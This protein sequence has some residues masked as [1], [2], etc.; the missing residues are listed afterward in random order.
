MQKRFIAISQRLFTQEY[1]EVREALAL[2][3][4]EFFTKYLPDFLML[5]LSYAQNFERYKPFIA[6]VILS[7][8]NDLSVCSDSELNRRRDDFEANIIESCIKDSIP[9]L[10]ICRGA[11]MIA[12]YF[13][14][15][16]NRCSNHTKPHMVRYI[17][18]SKNHN[19]K[20]GKESILESRRD[21]L[22]LKKAQ[23]KKT[24]ESAEKK[25]QNHKDL[26]ST[27]MDSNATICHF[28][29]LNEESFKESS[30]DILGSHSQCDKILESKKQAECRTIS[31][32]SL[33]NNLDS[34]SYTSNSAQSSNY[35]LNLETKANFAKTDSMKSKNFYVRV[36][37]YHNY[38]IQ[39]L[40]ENLS[41]LAIYD[42]D[43]DDRKDCEEDNA[44][45]EKKNYEKSYYK[46]KDYENKDLKDFSV[47]AFRHDFH[48]IFGIMWHI[49]RLEG[50]NE[51]CIFSLWKNAI[52]ANL[53]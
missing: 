30:K 43:N 45:S 48:N 14:S 33:N 34:H 47:E 46:R 11:Q 2:E 9:L 23:N 52:E 49:E 44:S 12:H 18:D 29:I 10:G 3:W 36:N 51:C 27:Q 39:K 22:P 15:T 31:N 20:H 1:G 38:A 37:S 21:F 8:G 13:N 7:G 24:L 50:M 40:G 28:E 19:S 6:G 42:K 4:G 41:A 25:V 17:L 35:D 53:I 32:S 26:E 5:P 16:I